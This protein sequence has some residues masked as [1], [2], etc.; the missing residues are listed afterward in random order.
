[1]AGLFRERNSL[2][3]TN[4]NNYNMQ[5]PIRSE[6]VQAISTVATG[7][8]T[9]AVLWLVQTTNANSERLTR[10]EERVLTVTSDRYTAT[11]AKKDGEVVA[12]RLTELEKRVEKLEAKK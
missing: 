5:T 1:M 12:H 2:A 11:E 3:V 9:A 10:I 8:T 6:F 4:A 7:L